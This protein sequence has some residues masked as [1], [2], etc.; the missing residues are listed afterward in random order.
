MGPGQHFGEL[1]LLG[2]RHRTATVRALK[3]TSVLSI[4]R[5]DFAALV[6]HLPAL[7]GALTQ[8]PAER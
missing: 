7:Q 1:A 8:P 3:D 2:D 6:E 4:A 5:Q